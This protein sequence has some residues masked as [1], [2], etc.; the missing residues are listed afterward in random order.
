MLALLP[1]LLTYSEETVYELNKR[2]L[3]L[4]SLCHNSLSNR[5]FEHIQDEKLKDN[6]WFDKTRFHQPN[7]DIEDSIF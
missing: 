7:F 6:F 4:N 1:T 2:S 5:T 3:Y